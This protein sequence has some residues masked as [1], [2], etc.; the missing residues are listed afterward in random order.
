MSAPK[1]NKRVGRPSKKLIE[2]SPKDGIVD[3]AENKTNRME[4][5][6][7]NPMIFKSIFSYL[8][9]MGTPTVY[10]KCYRDHMVMLATDNLTKCKIFIRIAGKDM[11]R[12]FCNKDSFYIRLKRDNL[13]N[14]FSNIDKSFDTIS[15]EIPENK[16]ILIISFRDF[17]INKKTE[18]S[19]VSSDTIDDEH[20]KELF[21][22][23]AR[24]AIPENTYTVRW[25]LPIKKFKKMINDVSANSDIATISK[26]YDAPLEINYSKDNTINYKDRYLS[27]DKINLEHNIKPG[28]VFTY[29][30]NI[31]HIRFLAFAKTSDYIK[32]L[33][34]E[35]EDFLFIS[36]IGDVKINTYIN[37]RSVD[38]RTKLY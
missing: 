21:A 9:N 29:T 26:S 18:Y 5:L 13:E 25:T 8:K 3:E 15:M 20:D 17:E 10:I 4:L 7:D 11:N 28:D 31:K 16:S 34:K 32:I 30:I 23:E 38:P 33:C 22:S 19:V 1:K 27:V 14:I 6:Y 24:L 35:D 36:N 37:C 2:R 12:Y